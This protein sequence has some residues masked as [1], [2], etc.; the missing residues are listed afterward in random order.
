MIR[1]GAPLTPN[2]VDSVIDYLAAAFPNKSPQPKLIPGSTEVSIKEWK[3]PTP[4]SRPHDPLV[5]PDGSIWYT[6]Q[7]A[8]LLGRFD[9]R[10][11]QFKEY[12]LPK[13]H[14]P[15]GLV[16][17]KEGNIW[18]TANSAAAVAKLDPK[19]GKVQEFKMPDPQSHDRR[20]KTGDAAYAPLESLRHGDRLERN[21]L[22]LRVRRQSA[23]QH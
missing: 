20:S 12:P 4:G 22:V 3:V 1:L 15:H 16:A 18:Y 13:A 17:D 8:D 14:G 7:R 5:A 23:G 21:S 19:T 9:P 6:G 11:E 10:T 2:K